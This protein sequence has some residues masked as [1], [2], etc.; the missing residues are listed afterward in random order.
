MKMRCGVALARL[1]EPEGSGRRC[2]RVAS[3]RGVGGLALCSDTVSVELGDVDSSTLSTIIK[4]PADEIIYPSLSTF[5]K[6]IVYELCGYLKG[7]SVH[8]N[9]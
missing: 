4:R 3:S 2:T 5:D 9:L 7:L 1:I 6:M 8:G